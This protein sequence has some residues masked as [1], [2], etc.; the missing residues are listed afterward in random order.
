M[1]FFAAFLVMAFLLTGCAGR[2][3]PASIVVAVTPTPIVETATPA[4][5]AT[6]DPNEWVTPA[7]EIL[8]QFNPTAQLPPP[9]VFTE[10]VAKRKFQ[11][12]NPAGFKYKDSSHGSLMESKEQDVMILLELFDHQGKAN[13]LG[14]L[15]VL[16]DGQMYHATGKPVRYQLAGYEGWIVDVESPAIY[17][18]AVG[19]LIIVDIDSAN[20]FYAVGLARWDQWEPKGIRFFTEVIDSISFPGFN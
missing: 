19:Q 5:T 2:P 16:L 1:R 6:P 9:S 18:N 7:S 11:L 3:Q 14:Y 8:L 15:D 20:L 13:A 10:T 12:T 17:G 4:S